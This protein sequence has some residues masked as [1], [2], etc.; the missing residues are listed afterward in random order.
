VSAAD[1]KKA[2]KRKIIKSFEVLGGNHSR[3]AVQSLASSMQ[4]EKA[5]K[6]RLCVV[7]VNLTNDECKAL[8][9]EH[10]DVGEVKLNTSFHDRVIFFRKVIYVNIC[11]F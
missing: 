10:N 8:G 7:Y 11:E 9:N 1:L 4:F 5:F 6:T 2:Y 3:L